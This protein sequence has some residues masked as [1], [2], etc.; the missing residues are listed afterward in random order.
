MLHLCIV[1]CCEVWVNLP[2]QKNPPFIRLS[3]IRLSFRLGSL[4][5]TYTSIQN[6]SCKHDGGSWLPGNIGENRWYT[7][8]TRPKELAP[9]LRYAKP[10]NYP[11]I[12]Q[13]SNV[14]C[15]VHIINAP[16]NILRRTLTIGRTLCAASPLAKLNSSHR[17]PLDQK[18]RPY[19]RTALVV[20]IAAPILALTKTRNGSS[21]SGP[22]SEGAQ[23]FRSPFCWATKTWGRLELARC[24]G[25]RTY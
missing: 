11:F 15:L 24:N 16:K 10:F 8:C 19:V 20:E 21:R 17:K 25:S 12:G 2:L 9:P 14:I 18:F 3:F 6:T 4:P 23:E 7:L 13:R 5:Y 1:Y 22:K